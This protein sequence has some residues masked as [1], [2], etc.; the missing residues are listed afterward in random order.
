M[1]GNQTDFERLMELNAT[2]IDAIRH[3]DVGWFDDQVGELSL[4]HI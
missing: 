3:N 4:I 1:N 2:Y